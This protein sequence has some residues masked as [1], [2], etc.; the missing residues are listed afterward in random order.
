MNY[1]SKNYS[2]LK[3]FKISVSIFLDKFLIFLEK[4]FHFLETFVCYIYY[5]RRPDCRSPSSSL[6]LETKT[7]RRCTSWTA[8]KPFSSK[9]RAS[10]SETLSSSWRCVNSWTTDK[11]STWIQT[12][13]WRIWPGK[14]FTK[15]PPSWLDTCD[16]ADSRRNQS[17][18]RGPETR[19]HWTM[20]QFWTASVVDRDAQLQWD[21]KFSS[22]HKHP[23]RQCIHKFR[24]INFSDF[25]TSF[26][27][28]HLKNFIFSKKKN[29]N[30]KI[31]FEIW[32]KKFFL[33][34][35]F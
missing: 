15:C 33:N 26:P 3:N 12:L 24:K 10:L 11:E 2:H 28:I 7:L 20:I 6:V 17:T 23:L 32:L 29:N 13:L 22:T 16:N 31:F 30:L 18:T 25:L 35:I 1:S 14:C 9:T 5:S 34:I 27:A 4:S 21:S 8:T 19:R